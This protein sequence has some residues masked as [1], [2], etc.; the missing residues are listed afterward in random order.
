VGSAQDG[1]AEARLAADAAAWAEY[2][3]RLRAAR[4]EAASMKK[5]IKAA[6]KQRDEPSARRTDARRDQATA[7]RR[8]APAEPRRGRG[9]A[10]GYGCRVGPS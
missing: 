7:H 1:L 6:D 4:D 5:A 2:G 9:A 10:A 3:S 8:V